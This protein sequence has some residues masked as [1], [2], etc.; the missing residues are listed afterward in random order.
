MFKHINKHARQDDYFL[1]AIIII[2]A[3]NYMQCFAFQEHIQILCQRQFLRK[4]KFKKK[5]P[6]KEKENQQYPVSI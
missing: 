2:I 6:R 5:I 3:C 4:L 1:Y